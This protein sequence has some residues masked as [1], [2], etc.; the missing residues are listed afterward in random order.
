MVL[1]HHRE[2]LSMANRVRRSYYELLRDTLDQQL[3]NHSLVASYHNFKEST[4]GYPFVEKKELKPRA[5]TPDKEFKR[6]NTFLVIFSEDVILPQHK[7]YL[8]FFDH[9]K[10]TLSNL[11]RSESVDFSLEVRPQRKVFRCARFF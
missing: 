3:L 11:K 10:T 9:N 8:H 5:R 6:H 1:K 2:T 7:K 4:D